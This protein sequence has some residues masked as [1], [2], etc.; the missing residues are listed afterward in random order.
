MSPT[1][2]GAQEQPKMPWQRTWVKTPSAQCSGGQTRKRKRYLKISFGKTYRLFFLR[3][4]I[5]ATSP[6]L[7]IHSICHALLHIHS[8]HSLSSHPALKCSPLWGT[9]PKEFHLLPSRPQC[10]SP[11]PLPLSMTDIHSGPGRLGCI[12]FKYSTKSLGLS[13]PLFPYLQNDWVRWKHLCKMISNNPLHSFAHS[14]SK[15]A[16]FW[17]SPWADSEHG[18]QK[19]N[20]KR[21]WAVPVLLEWAYLSHW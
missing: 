13:D 3:K 17:D 20:S 18:Y 1:S 9:L 4:G 12:K 15:A 19:W 8:C 2:P 16:G 7:D 14:V 10:W 11:G 5:V 6:R 21:F